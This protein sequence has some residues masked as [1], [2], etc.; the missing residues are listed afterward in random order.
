MQGLENLRDAFKA[1][2]DSGFSLRNDV[3][4]LKAIQEVDQYGGKDKQRRR[5]NK[6]F[7][8]KNVGFKLSPFPLLTSDSG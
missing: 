4:E 5:K 2:F 8:D 7:G 6:G 3:G 1:L